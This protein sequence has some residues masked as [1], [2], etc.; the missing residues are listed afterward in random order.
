MK[1]L[2]PLL[3]LA[4]L[5]GCSYLG[6]APE[7]QP[8]L[9]DLQPAGLPEDAEPLPQV[10]LEELTGVYEDVL[11]VTEDAATRRQ[12]M[13]RL[14][15]IEMLEAEARL[16]AG[17]ADEALFD[18]AIAAYQNLLRQE[19]HN[20][21]NDEL[22][23]QLSRAYELNGDS[24]RSLAMLEQ[25]NAAWPDSAHATEARFRRAENYFAAADYGR[26][27]AA[28][29]GVIAAGPDS[30]Y[31]ANALYMQGWSGFKQGRYDDAVVSFTATL[32]QLV[33][34]DNDLEALPRGDRELA[35]D[36]LRMLAVIFSY[37]QGADTIAQ[38]Y[39]QLGVRP[40]QHLLYQSLGELYLSQERYR[41]SAEVYKAHNL[42]FV[43]S[44]VAHR[45]QMRVIAAYEAG[46]FPELIVAEKQAY[47]AAFSV[48]GPY[49]QQADES[50]QAE[51]R[52]RL[53]QFT[54]ELAEYHHA[55]AQALVSAKEPDDAQADGPVGAEARAHYAAASDYYQLF[56][57]SFPDDPALAEMGFQLASSR[58]EAG[59]YRAAI[60]SYEWV[61]YDFPEYSQR[62]EAGYRAILAY[63]HLPAAEAV[64]RARIASELAFAT[65]FSDDPRGAAVLAHAADA[66]LALGEYQQAIA[67]AG[68][69]GELQPAAD[70]VALLTAS[71]VT[72]H[73]SFELQQ[74]PEA[75]AAY[76]DA[77][78]LL[79]SDDQRRPMVVDRYAASIYRQGEEAAAA[80]EHLLAADQFARVV[81][82]APASAI[83]AS[84]Q[85]DAAAQYQQVGDIAAATGLLRD[86]LEQHPD[87]ELAV[88]ASAQLVANY[89]AQ[90]QWVAAAAELERV[91][92]RQGDAEV[93]RQALFLAASYYDRA[94][95][96]ELAGERYRQYAATWR[97]PLEP[98]LEAIQ[99]VIELQAQS[100]GGEQRRYWLAELVAAHEAAG[101]G[102]TERSRYLAAAASS[103]LAGDAFERYRALQLTHP[104]Q[105]SLAAKKAAMEEAL[106]AYRASNEYGVQEF[107][108]LATYRMAL[109]YQQLGDALL[110]SE[111]PA[112]I[113]E[114]A[115]EQYEMLLEEQAYPFE[116]KAIA[117]H[118]ANA[119]RSWQGVY[120]QWV[121]A[122]FAEL[123]GLL[124]ARY[125]KSEITADA[126]A[127][128][129]ADTA[130]LEAMWQAR[131]EDDADD[132]E[133][134][135]QYAILQRRQ[136][137]FRKAEASYL[138]ALEVAEETTAVHCNL[139]ILYDLYLGQPEPALR[140]YQ[141][142]QE[143]SAG[144][145]PRVALWI[146]DLERRQLSLVQG[147]L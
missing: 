67:T 78:A 32:D 21:G 146:A 76:R 68:R 70:P 16:A 95:E 121:Q 58:L 103:E 62:A 127:A 7:Q 134:L 72:G 132:V 122:S 98:R 92:D 89:E 17:A 34:Q 27:E 138:A 94:G 39:E 110:A 49:W 26:A 102:Q 25:L 93:R 61:A 64:E 38:T 115:L 109:I 85:F 19:P 66:L 106:A 73:G 100:G 8:T 44:P 86:F 14:A 50:M 43:D 141:R 137:R 105:A 125:G 54:E 113:D 107:A 40:Y 88:A 142:Y 74:Y 5:G 144:A 114:L 145:D 48:P 126:N 84:A 136:G 51:M 129:G 77:L 59:D 45:L 15:D 60:A 31:F 18:Q 29:A 81:S 3:A 1:R 130:Q 116:E 9:A 52:P 63:Q 124:P 147:G 65:T 79:G 42:R 47:V 101:A 13:R 99:R 143:L 117:I 80:G 135:N 104:L 46:G 22:L 57:D 35:G 112:E 56:I 69:L 2:P 128:A 97:E 82:V 23:Y 20:P 53:R 75:E 91:H 140:H 55:A 119:R 133:A 11:E 28:Y 87:H 111:R 83:R 96:S 41:D 36:C 24:E 33:P 6:M 108:T 30:D 131:L 120:D 118:E 71:L 123:A 139:G 10:S 90:Q 4:L 37:Q 12:V